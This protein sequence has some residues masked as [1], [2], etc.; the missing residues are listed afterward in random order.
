MK[1]DPSDIQIHF[2]LFVFFCDPLPKLAQVQPQS[3]IFS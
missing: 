1:L 2:G 3:L